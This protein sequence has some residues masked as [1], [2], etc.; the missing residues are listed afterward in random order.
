MYLVAMFCKTGKQFQKHY[1]I[2][3]SQVFVNYL[4]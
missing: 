3:T 1:K 2:N 4:K